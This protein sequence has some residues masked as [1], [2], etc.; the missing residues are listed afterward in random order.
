[1]TPTYRMAGWQPRTA[2]VD[3]APRMVDA[4]Y[5]NA[6]VARTGDLDQ[7]VIYTY[8]EPALLFQLRLAGLRWVRPIKDLAI[9]GPSGSVP[10]LPSFVVVGPQS[11]RSPGFAEQFASTRHRLDLIGTYSCQPSDLVRLDRTDWKDEHTDEL[12]ELYRVK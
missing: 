3:L 2:L 4:A 6:G 10:A 11:Y 9:A 5:R 7:I 8:G 1:M 12:I